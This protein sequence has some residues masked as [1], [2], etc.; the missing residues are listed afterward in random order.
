MATS[1]IEI[2]ETYANKWVAE[3]EWHNGQSYT[4]ARPSA[5]SLREMFEKLAE[6]LSNKMDAPAPLPPLNTSPIQP[7]APST[8]TKANVQ[9]TPSVDAK[10]GV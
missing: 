9:R 1:R 7:S 2:E 10:V 4:F 3:V 5:N 6:L 8:P